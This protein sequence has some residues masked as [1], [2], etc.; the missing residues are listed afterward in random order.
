MPGFCQGKRGPRMA[1]LYPPLFHGAVAITLGSSGTCL[2]RM[3]TGAGPRTRVQ[4][5]HVYPAQTCRGAGMSNGNAE[6]VMLSFHRRWG[7]Q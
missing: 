1:R 2:A 7:L 5:A 6:R 4:T 3:G